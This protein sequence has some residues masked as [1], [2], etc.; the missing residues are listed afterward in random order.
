V[1]HDTYFQAVLRLRMGGALLIW[2]K[3]GVGCQHK[4]FELN[5]TLFKDS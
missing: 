4:D 5:M 2:I 1:E 3:F